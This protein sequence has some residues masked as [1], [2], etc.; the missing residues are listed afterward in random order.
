MTVLACKAARNVLCETGVLQ[1][2]AM[3]QDLQAL[4]HTIRY[5]SHKALLCVVQ[6]A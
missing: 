1:G 6:K 3:A 4:Y 2:W 5:S